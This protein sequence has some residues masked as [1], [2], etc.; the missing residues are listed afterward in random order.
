MV[1]ILWPQRGNSTAFSVENFSTFTANRWT[2]PQSRNYI[3]I[4]QRVPCV[5]TRVMYICFTG[6]KCWPTQW[7][8]THF[9]Y[10]IL[11]AW[12]RRHLHSQ[13]A[14]QTACWLNLCV[15]VLP[16]GLLHDPLFSLDTPS[17]LGLGTLGFIVAHEI[18]HGFD[19]SGIEF[20]EHGVR[21]SLLSS[22][23]SQRI[24]KEKMSC[25]SN[26]YSNAFTTEYSI[27]GTSV[28]LKVINHFLLFR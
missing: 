15:L 25:V 19:N 1:W 10:S 20:D 3:V 18:M 16:L 22:P 14:Y 12:V 21:N 23:S 6:G 4:Q 27:N 26:Q 13:I 2:K 28:V 17:Y 24:F 7:S 5:F 11:T 9:I 8:P